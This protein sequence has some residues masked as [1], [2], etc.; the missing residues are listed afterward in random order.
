MAPDHDLSVPATLAGDVRGV[1]GVDQAQAL[2]TPSHTTGNDP[3][4][5]APSRPAP[6]GPATSANPAD[7]PPSDG[8]RNAPPCSS[9]WNEKQTTVPAFL[10]YPTTLPYAPCG[11]L[12]GQVRKAYGIDASVDTGL[13]GSSATVAVIDAFASP[14]I[15]ADATEY[16]ERNDPTHPFQANR[17]SQVVFPVN[18]DLE[19]PDGCDAAGWYGEET[20]D[21]EAVHAMAPGARIVYVGGSDCQ[22]ISL[23]TKRS[24]R[25]FDDQNLAI[26]TRIGYHDTTG[27]G[28]PNGLAFVLGVRSP[29]RPRRPKTACVM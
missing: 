12:P 18:P 29:V 6:T 1:I 27:L 7:V 9:Y 17:F 21:I 3:A 16:F 23:G 22:D 28:I 19:G 8:F 25:T 2:M 15:V 26:R 5:G 20:L 11:Y 13:T 24:I 14:T 4:E 10:D